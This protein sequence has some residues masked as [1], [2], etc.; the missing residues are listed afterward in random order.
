MRNTQNNDRIVKFDILGLFDSRNIYM[1]LSNPYK[2]FVGENGLGKTT[3]LNIIYYTLSN[4]FSKLARIK[5]KEVQIHY[6]SG[7]QFSF[8]KSELGV[9]GQEEFLDPR[10]TLVIDAI[11]EILSDDQ[12]LDLI[13][14]LNSNDRSEIRNTYEKYTHIINDSISVPSMRI[15]KALSIMYDI[16]LRKYHEFN[17]LNQQELNIIYFP[18]YRRIEEDLKN[19]GIKS[20]LSHHGNNRLIQFGMEDVEL[21]ISNILNEIKNAT[22]IGFSSLAGELLNQYASNHLSINNSSVII[23]SEILNIVMERIGEN[24][25]VPTKLDILNL[26]ESREIF[27]NEEKYKYLLNF[28]SE[29]I[30]LYYGQDHLNNVLKDFS[31]ICSKYLRNKSV[32]YNESKLTVNV[33]DNKARVINLKDLSSG[34]KQIISIFSRIYL[35]SSNNLIV[36]FDEP[37]LSLSLEW[38]KELL[39]DILASDRVEMLISVTHSPFIFQNDLDSIAEDMNEIVEFYG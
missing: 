22:L 5:F 16:S 28:I 35:E 38:Q 13:N 39:P 23:T 9:F 4:Q 6:L 19:L 29:L 24:I 33:I 1:D 18:T 3:I 36:L 8:K 30:K 15:R 25:T 26:V 37:E 14:S 11:N 12:K 2:I 17:L 27:K 10:V 34:E 32:V 7:R 21:A 31:A 20:D